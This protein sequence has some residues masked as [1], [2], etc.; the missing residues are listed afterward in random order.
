MD[1]PHVTR[2]EPGRSP[3]GELPQPAQ[4]GSFSLSV[5]FTAQRARI[6]AAFAEPSLRSRWF[7]VPGSASTARHE[8]D[9]RVGGG[10]SA[11]N[12]FSSGDV[13]EHVAY[14]SRF[15]DIVPDAR[16]VWTYE[17]QV[18]GVRRWVSLVTVELADHDG[19]SRL[20]WTESYAYLVT[21]GD[22]SQDAAHLR[23]GTRLLLNGLS[24]LVE[25][26]RFPGLDRTGTPVGSP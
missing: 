19:G 14:H 10:E 20:T 2:A 9:F 17:A 25:P 6:F 8:L 4:H 26:D 24:V 7:R 12:V 15:L 5:D 22:G 11:R 18:N 13:E 16:I 3:S 23:G 1:E 21:T